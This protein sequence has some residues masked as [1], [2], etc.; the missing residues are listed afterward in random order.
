MTIKASFI[1][2]WIIR[3][4]FAASMVLVVLLYIGLYRS[5]T[6]R[7]I[8]VIHSEQLEELRLE[9]NAGA[10]YLIIAR[11]HVSTRQS[12][13][14]RRATEWPGRW[15]H[16][17]SYFTTAQVLPGIQRVSYDDSIGNGYHVGY[18]I[19]YWLLTSLAIVGVGISTWA[20]RRCHRQAGFL[21]GSSSKASSD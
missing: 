8:L 21:V 6:A 3:L 20:L 16:D 9:S 11:P 5:A 1:L 18:I 15:E 4:A 17:K 13:D 19:E 14:W 2:L 12:L 7:D 10:V